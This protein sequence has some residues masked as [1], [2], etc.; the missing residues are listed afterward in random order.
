MDEQPPGLSTRRP[1][2]PSRPPQREYRRHRPSHTLAIV[3]GILLGAA[4]IGIAVVL[5][6]SSGDDAPATTQETVAALPTLKIVFPE[7]FTRSEMAGRIG[8]VNRIAKEKRKLETSLVPKEYLVETK[9]STVPAE[10]GGPKKQTS[11]EGFLFPATY[12]F[13]P[14]TTARQLADL[15]L[16]AFRKAW[17]TVDLS[18]AKKRNLTPYDVLTIASMIEAE[19]RLPKERALVAAVVYNRLKAGMALG[20]DATLRYGLDIPPNKSITQS[21]LEDK[22]PYN[23]RIH[24][25]LPP[26]PI[27]NPGL[28]SMKAAAKPATVDYLYYARKQDC[29][30]HFFTASESEFLAFLDGPR[31]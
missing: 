12:D 23:T 11:L 4:A 3:L 24:T 15:Q 19:V 14:K 27:G 28:A 1:D 6:R 26:T 10:F 2:G 8:V 25:G 17:A 31:C 18:Y 30:S 22:T 29:K 20:I 5:L 7:G 9:S 21:Q 16:L 13:T